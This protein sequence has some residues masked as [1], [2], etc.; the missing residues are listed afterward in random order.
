VI[1]PYYILPLYTLSAEVVAAVEAGGLFDVRRVQLF[2]SNW[3]PHDDTEDDND[4]V[5]GAGESG[6]N[7]ARVTRAVLEA[8][9]TPH[10]AERVLDELFTVF[11]RLV[12]KHLEKEKTKF[13][14]IVLVLSLR[15][16][17]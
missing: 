12:T 9:L 14:V 15:A 8:L 1:E 17:R 10:F 2:Q 3:D 5:D 6:E 11:A 16:G 4:V 7:V 13:T